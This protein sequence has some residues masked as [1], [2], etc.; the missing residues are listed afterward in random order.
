MELE[1]DPVSKATHYTVSYGPSPGNYLWGVPNTG[2]V[3][4]TIIGD[5]SGGCFVVRAVNDCAPSDPSNE[6][7]T[8]QI[9]PQVLGLSTTGG[10]GGINPVTFWFGLMAFIF[11]LR[12]VVNAKN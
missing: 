2:N 12:L 8:G 1:W 9:A 11:G 7:C 3:T 5:I 6:F 10:S 4:S